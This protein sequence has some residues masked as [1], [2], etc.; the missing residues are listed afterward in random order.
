[1]YAFVCSGFLSGNK[2]LAH[3][4][5][6][7]GIL[8]NIL[9]SCIV[10]IFNFLL[11]EMILGNLVLCCFLQLFFLLQLLLLLGMI[12]TFIGPECLPLICHVSLIVFEILPVFIHFNG[13]FW[14]Q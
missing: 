12:L 14:S 6:F 10:S 3:T 7:T 1:M 13:E 5:P 4:S 2:S 8:F 11:V 9:L